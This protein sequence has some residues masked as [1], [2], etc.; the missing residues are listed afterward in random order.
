M[1]C[2]VLCA[3]DSRPLCGIVQLLLSQAYIDHRVDPVRRRGVP[4]LY[5]P[6]QCTMPR[7]SPNGVPSP[8]AAF[9]PRD[10]HSPAGAR[11]GVASGHSHRRDVWSVLCTTSDA[12]SVTQGPGLDRGIRIRLWLK[13]GGVGPS[14]PAPPKLLNAKGKMPGAS[15]QSH[16]ASGWGSSKMGNIVT[17]AS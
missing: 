8:L 14:L 4:K 16:D 11:R 6:K 5:T 9:H 13:E 17:S 15:P 1:V 10:V 12:G 2:A 7:P 3:V